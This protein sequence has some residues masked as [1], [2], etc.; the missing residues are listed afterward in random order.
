[1][2]LAGARSTLIVPIGRVLRPDRVA[3]HADFLRRHAA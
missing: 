3:S 2:E 1:L